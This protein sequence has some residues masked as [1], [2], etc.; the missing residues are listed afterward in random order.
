[1]VSADYVNYAIRP[2]KTI[3]RKLIFESLSKLT[4]VY[5]FTT[6]RYIG[7]GAQWFAD[8]VMAHKYLQIADMISIE[9]DSYLADR[10]LFNKPYACVSV[11]KGET[12]SVLP[13][14]SLEETLHLVWL[15]YDSSL[16]GP[17]L[18]DIAT[19][20]QRV[21]SGSVV[22]ISLNAHKNTLP[23]QDEEGEPF[24]SDSE[25]LQFFA[26]DL[27]PQTLPKGVMQRSKYPAFLA[28]LLFDHMRRQVRTAGRENE[29]IMPF[30]NIAYSD[31]AP[32]ITIA[33]AIVDEACAEK[34]TQLIES[35]GMAGYMDE[36]RQL[37]IGVPPL[38]IKERVS[39]DQLMPCC[40]TPTEGDVKKLG[41][42]L[43]PNQIRAYH[44]FYR[45]YPMFGE[46]AP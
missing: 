18:Q 15:D 33:A 6:Y 45:Y 16:D 3:E 39:L 43:K 42:R 24:S 32:M 36:S 27:I 8:F 23:N 13:K 2:N 28:E 25:R 9:K 31:N 29:M 7:L 34:T 26:G 11:E 4:P 46:I 37:V 30:F 17:V 41:F 10:A 38:T 1:M 40:E 21:P 44:R 12:D 14:L 22:I 20:C 19:L 5:D 35:Q